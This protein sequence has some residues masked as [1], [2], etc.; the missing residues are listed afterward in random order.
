MSKVRKIYLVC[1]Y[2]VESD[3]GEDE[4]IYLAAFTNRAEARK[5]IEGA[6]KDPNELWGFKIRE[7]E[8]YE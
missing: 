7:I 8:L 6:R 4:P 1:G 3:P 2:D 5:Y